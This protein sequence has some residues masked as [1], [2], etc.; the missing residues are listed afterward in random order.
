MVL[1]LDLEKSFDTV[2]WDFH[3]V[4]L[5]IKGFGPIWQSWTHGCICNANFSIIINGRPWG[6]IIPSRG[7]KQ[8]FLFPV[9]IHLSC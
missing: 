7:I 4:V 9:F 6:K 2:D 3:D 1:K 5:E 8:V